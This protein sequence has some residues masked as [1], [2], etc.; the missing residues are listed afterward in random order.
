MGEILRH[1]AGVS[2]APYFG[3]TF[4]GRQCHRI[5]RKLGLVADLMDSTSPGPGAVAWRRESSL[6]QG[7][8]PTLNRADTICDDD[9]A[10]FAT[11]SSAFVDG[12]KAGLARFSVSPKMHTLCWHAAAFL[13]RFRSLGRYSEQ[14]MEALHG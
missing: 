6:W 3:G 11:D 10:Q 5:G 13:L 2:P 8:L 12:L 9:I 1:D 7:L 14:G 4:K